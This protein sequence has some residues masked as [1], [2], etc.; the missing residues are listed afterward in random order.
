VFSTS[1]APSRNEIDALVDDLVGRYGEH[2]GEAAFNLAAAYRSLRAAKQA[3]AH[4]WAALRLCGADDDT[5]D[6]ASVN[7]PPNARGRDAREFATTG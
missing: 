3:N 6:L 7:M 5:F 1:M 4:H 2:A